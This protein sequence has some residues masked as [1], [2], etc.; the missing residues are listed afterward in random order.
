MKQAYETGMKHENETEA[1]PGEGLHVL[2]GDVLVHSHMCVNNPTHKLKKQY[3]MLFLLDLALL[4]LEVAPRTL[5]IGLSSKF[6][7]QISVGHPKWMDLKTF[8]DRFL[9][10]ESVYF[11]S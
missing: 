2:Q 3:G 9:F 5:K 6:A 10:P 11:D 1:A 4:G 7:A 8:R